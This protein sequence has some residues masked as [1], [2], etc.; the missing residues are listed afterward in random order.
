MVLEWC[1]VDSPAASYLKEPVNPLHTI[2]I[3]KVPCEPG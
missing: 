2:E 1:E 3:Y